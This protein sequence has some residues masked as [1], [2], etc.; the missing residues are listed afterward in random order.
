[1]V[2]MKDELEAAFS[3]TVAAVEKAQASRAGMCSTPQVTAQSCE[4]ASPVIERL[5]PSQQAQEPPREGEQYGKAGHI[6]IMQDARYSVRDRE[7]RG[8]AT[9]HLMTFHLSLLS[10]HNN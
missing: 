9:A 7:A 3:S 5:P 8:D 6:P 10:F 4:G 1:M 2:Q